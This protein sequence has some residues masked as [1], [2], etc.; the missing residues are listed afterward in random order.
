MT[1]ALIGLIGAMFGAVTAFAGSALSDRRRMRQ[2]DIQWRRDQR[3]AA[4]EGALRHLLRAANMRSELTVKGG[5]L[6]TVL[7]PEHMR[8]WFGDLVEAQFWMH[9]L[10]SRCEPAQSVRLGD[11]AEKLD[12]AI[13]SLNAG[14]GSGKKA[15]GHIDPG[16]YGGVFEALDE[17]IAS[18]SK[19]AQLYMSIETRTRGVLDALT[20]AEPDIR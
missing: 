15:P 7:S 2:E 12:E 19:C 6:T 10:T 17:A 20:A 13:R 5:T 1:A 16:G 11:S 3:V 4:Y 14:R 9:T 8:E 18:V